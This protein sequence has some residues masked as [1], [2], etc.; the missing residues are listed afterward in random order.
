[1]NIRSL[2]E[3]FMKILLTGAFGNVGLSTLDELL[4]QNHDVTIY[5]LKNRRNLRLYKKNYIH[6]VKVIWGDLRDY[7]KVEESVRGKD[8]VIHLGAVIPPLADHKP[9]LAE[10][11]NVGGT[12]N[13]IMAIEK[14]ERMP[15]LIYSSSVAIYGDRVKSPL[16]RVTD[17]INP[18]QKDYYAKQKIK[19]ESMIRASSI[20]NWAILRLSAI[21]SMD[22]LHIDPIMFDMP[23]DTS[24]EICY[25]RDVGIAMVNA[26]KSDDIWGKTLHIAG[27]ERC[28]ISYREFIDKMMEIFG[29]G[30]RYLPEE[31]FSKEGFHCG[32]METEESQRLL[33]FQNTTLDDYYSVV[34]KK[35]KTS[36]FF[37]RIFRKL[38]RP[39]FLIKSPYYRKYLKEKRNK[40]VISHG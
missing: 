22:N 16:I 40:T 36:R 26:I 32:F 23:L 13:I 7:N 19:C 14:Q 18:N 5:E 17:P 2:L 15:K 20:N 30:K 25:T 39:V 29:F 28:R 27:G 12:L 24:I 8:A 11:V 38:I 10:S 6:K 34:D 4:K 37:V 9:D 33:Q 1:M 31:A 21:F 35:Y 3:G